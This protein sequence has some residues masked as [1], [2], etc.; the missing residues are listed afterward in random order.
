[1]ADLSMNELLVMVHAL[2]MKK[3]SDKPYRNY[4]VAGEVDNRWEGLVTRGLAAARDRPEELGGRT[5]FV[6]K[7]GRAA[8]K[9]YGWRWAEMERK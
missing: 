6:S 7:E 1:M 4:Y 8:L 3:P 9:S 2:G 5:Y